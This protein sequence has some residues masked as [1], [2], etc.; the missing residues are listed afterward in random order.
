MEKILRIEEITFKKE[1]DDWQSYDGYQV[2]TDKQTI[3]MGISNSSCCCENW[4]YVMSEDNLAEFIDSD[5]IEITT[6]DTELKTGLL[7]EYGLDSGD[8]M[9]INFNTSKGL[10]Q[11]VAYNAHN[12]YYGHNA[13]F[14]SKQL[15]CDEYL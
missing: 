12:G 9:F 8:A 2:I 6:T 1:K 3:K 13:V 11:F 10:L 4:G 14:I 5:L 15:N 7:P